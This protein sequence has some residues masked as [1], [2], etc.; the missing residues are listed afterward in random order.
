MHYTIPPAIIHNVPSEASMIGTQQIQAVEGFQAE[1]STLPPHIE[2]RGKYRFTY[3]W[4]E[5]VRQDWQ[6]VTTPLVG[7]KLQILEVGSFE[8]CSTTWIMDNILEHPESTLT[9]I[10][11]FQ[12]SAEHLGPD[13]N[14]GAIEQT[15]HENVQ[16]ARNFSKLRILKGRSADR[17]IQLRGESAQ[18]DLIYIDASHAAIDVLEDIALSWPMLRVGGTFV[19]DDYRWGL[20]REEF[21]RPRVAIDAFLSSAKPYIKWSER[22]GQ[23]WGTKI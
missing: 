21:E 2:D 22:N 4:F 14:L 19:L 8:G 9:A 18:F 16:K 15:F 7:A 17:L 20:D 23:I 6:E 5:V 13:F 1:Q 11:W 12:G 3:P 10:D